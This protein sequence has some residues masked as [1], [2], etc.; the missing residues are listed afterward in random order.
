MGRSRTMIRSLLCA[1]LSL[2]VCLL[3]ARGW[4]QVVVP[5]VQVEGAAPGRSETAADAAAASGRSDALP[6][7]R[8]GAAT[9][10]DASGDGDLPSVDAPAIARSPAANLPGGAKAS[11]CRRSCTSSATVTATPRTGSRLTATPPPICGSPIA[12]RS[13]LARSKPA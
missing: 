10:Y 9:A 4:A 13:I 3:A 5:E 1:G 2:S 8:V 6:S 12:S 11:P 7:R